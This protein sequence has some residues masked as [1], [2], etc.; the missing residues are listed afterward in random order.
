MPDAA[1]VTRTRL[2]TTNLSPVSY[3]KLSAKDTQ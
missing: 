3:S 1:P 2:L